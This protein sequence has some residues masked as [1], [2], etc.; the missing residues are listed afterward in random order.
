MLKTILFKL[1][2]VFFIYR[3]YRKI[4]YIMQIKSEIITNFR[5]VLQLKGTIENVQKILKEYRN[6]TIG[7]FNLK[8]SRCIWMSLILYRF[9]NEMDVSEDLWIESRML[10]ISLLKSETDLESTIRKYLITFN[11]WQNEDLKDL[12]TQIGLNYYN[13]IQIKNSIE[14]TGNI[15]TI[16][17]WLPHYENLIDK[18]RL[19]SKSI[20]ILEKIDELVIN[21]EEKK[22]N[23][24]KEIMDRAYWD[25]I[26][27]D[28]EN[29]NLDMVYNNLFELKTTLLDIIP[30]SVDTNFLDEYFDI[31]Y[32]KH[33]VTN[34]VFDKEYLFKLF[35]FVI[36]ILKEWDSESFNEKYDDEIKG[37]NNIE[38]SNNHIIR[39]VL[40]K[41]IILALDLKN[42]KVLWNIILKK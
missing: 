31:D 3:K 17:H 23:I 24:I 10:I 42:R 1:S 28:M 18:I 19:Y 5:N 12:A 40:Q 26:E 7:N 38:G 33:I 13:L 9:K 15:D 16:E 39:C 22:Y 30:K 34:G 4:I 37:I 36:K 2:L 41:L 29:N 25:K 20:G 14:K 11:K 32:I 21:F 6:M 27:E 8:D 35:N